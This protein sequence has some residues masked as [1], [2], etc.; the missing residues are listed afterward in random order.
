MSLNATL[1]TFSPNM[2]VRSADMNANF[3]ALNT[4][5]TF[6]GTIPTLNSDNGTLTSN[7][8]GAILFAGMLGVTTPGD[9][10]N[11]SLTKGT[12][13]LHASTTHSFQLSATIGSTVSVSGVNL[14]YSPTYLKLM[15]GS[16]RRLSTFTASGSSGT[17]NHNNGGKPDH[18]MLY[19]NNGT[20]EQMAYNYNTM[21]ATQVSWSTGLGAP[22]KALA[23]AF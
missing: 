11:A 8:N 16:V 6:G 10:V 15:T 9:R 20:S 3:N 7:G 13:L 23:Y 21:T 14:V 19:A 2:P 17:S 18:I 5:T 12:V 4:N 22:F 1:I